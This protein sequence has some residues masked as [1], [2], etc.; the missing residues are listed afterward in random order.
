[1]QHA[2]VHGLIQCRTTLL[3]LV[4]FSSQFPFFLDLWCQTE[5]IKVVSDVSRLLSFFGYKFH[6]VT[7]ICLICLQFSYL[8]ESAECQLWAMPSPSGN[9]LNSRHP[10]EIPVTNTNTDT[11]SFGTRVS[12]E[13]LTEGRVGSVPIQYATFVISSIV[14]ASSSRVNRLQT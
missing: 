7:P 4:P 12:Y 5:L 13:G 11:D 2:L 3:L 14:S 6:F 9:M 1:M 10:D 8:V